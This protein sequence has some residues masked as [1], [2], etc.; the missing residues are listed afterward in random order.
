MHCKMVCGNAFFSCVQNRGLFFTTN[1][2]SRDSA[3]M[4]WRPPQP[5]LEWVEIE[6]MGLLKSI[7]FPFHIFRLFR[8]TESM[9]VVLVTYV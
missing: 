4:M 5:H 1:A 6:F 3:E 2:S 9:T 7:P 8:E